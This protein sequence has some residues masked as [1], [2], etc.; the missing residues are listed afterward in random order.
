MFLS[1]GTAARF[2]GVSISTLRRWE[3]SKKLIP[4]WGRVL[5]VA[6]RFFPSSKTCSCCGNKKEDLSLKDRVF[7]CSD[8]GLKIDR[9]LN[10]ALNLEKLVNDKVRSA[11]AECTPVEITAM[12]ENGKRFS[13]TSIEE[14]GNKRQKLYG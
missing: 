4:I 9:D 3:K 2:L 11:R 14:S 7:N 10:A 6:D 13:S 8:C 12:I 5:Y 1:I